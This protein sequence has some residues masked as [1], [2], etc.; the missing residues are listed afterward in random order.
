MFDVLSE[1]L[2]RVFKDLRGHGRL[3]EENISD[4]LREVR[5]ALLEADVA[6]A[7]VRDF[8]QHVRERSLDKEVLTSLTPGQALIKIVNEELVYLMGENH[9]P[10]KLNTQPP[11]GYSSGRTPGSRKD[12]HGCKTGTLDQGKTT[13]KG[14]CCQLRCIS[15][16]SN[17]TITDIGK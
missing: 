12:N 6:L 9:E 1:K 11:C 14:C 17:Q 15:T 10:L 13:Q 16:R 3:T 4:G 8:I 5:M 7:V 2:S